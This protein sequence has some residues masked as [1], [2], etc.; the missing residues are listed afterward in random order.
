VAKS[1]HSSVDAEKHEAFRA[2][3]ADV[4]RTADALASEHSI[5]RAE[6]FCRTLRNEWDHFFS[7]YQIDG[8]CDENN[9]AAL[10]AAAKEGVIHL[11][12][13]EPRTVK[14]V[15]RLTKYLESTTYRWSL[16]R[17]LKEEGVEAV[18]AAIDR[19]TEKCRLAGI[20]E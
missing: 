8:S 17:Q 6:E 11:R 5:E 15:E 3:V 13:V 14:E 7:R 10:A 1:R 4:R 20:E 16:I 12:V 2:I 9:H 18:R 19:Q